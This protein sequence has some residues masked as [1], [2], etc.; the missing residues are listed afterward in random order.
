M[1]L[2]AGSAAVTRF[3]VVA[4]P[5]EPDF[6]R[7]RFVE[8][9]PQSEVRERIGLLPFE[10]EAPY[11]VGHDRW[12]FR[13]RID[14]RRPEA[15]AVRELV[16]DLVRAEL[17]TSGQQFVG[18]KK[19]RELR[20]LA[21]EE[22]LAKTTPR[23]RVLECCL[24]RDVLYVASTAKAH[25]GVVLQIGRQLGIQAEYLTP[26]MAD[27]AA[28]DPS[29][30]AIVE[31]REPGQ[32]VLGCRALKHLLE[33]PDF[34]LE[35]DAGSAR[36]QT[37]QAKITLSGE[38][39]ADVFEYLERGAEILSAKLLV[40]DYH[41]RFD[42]LAWRVSGL[43]FERRRYEHWSEALDTRLERIA[44]LFEL[45]DERYSA[46][47]GG[48]L[49][50]TTFVVPAHLAGAANAAGS[51]AADAGAAAPAGDASGPDDV[52]F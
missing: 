32:S 52:P 10:P 8:I 44:A 14:R 25:L 26:W 22:L 28:E 42:G 2:L 13:I 12:A 43:G 11:R 49:A 17:A 31:L 38:V 40:G 3:K 48:L 30:G 41:F 35:P 19:R 15:S 39:M 18:S 50:S 34:L 16:A 33:D 47:R 23:T 7:L 20:Q 9:A 5:A 46:M 27:A 6:D 1:G 4:K 37:R 45:L 36:L 24:D 21:E 29:L 51:D